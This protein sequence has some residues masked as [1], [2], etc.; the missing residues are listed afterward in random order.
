MM[1]DIYVIRHGETEDNLNDLS[2]G[3]GRNPL[4]TKKGEIQAIDLAYRLIEVSNP[5]KIPIIYSSPLIRSLQT[6]RP[7]SQM[8]GCF[9][10]EEYFLIERYLGSMEGVSRKIIF[11]QLDISSRGRS[12][13]NNISGIEPDDMISQRLNLLIEK[14]DSFQNSSIYLFS[15]GILSSYLCNRFGEDFELNNCDF[16]KYEVGDRNV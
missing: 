11:N 12:A 5:S 7:L 6:A 3:G 10:K 1:N 14:L 16:K 9:I 8:L 15:H 2:S 4:L 13:L